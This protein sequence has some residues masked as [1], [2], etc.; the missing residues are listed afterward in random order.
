MPA[1]EI[2]FYEKRCNLAPFPPPA[3]LFFHFFAACFFFPSVHSPGFLRNED[4]TG[5]D[6]RWPDR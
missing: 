1:R 3:L 4:E 5:F 2:K 6:G